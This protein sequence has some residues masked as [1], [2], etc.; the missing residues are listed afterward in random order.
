M[1]LAVVESERAGRNHRLQRVLFV[2]QLWQRKGG[3]G[4]LA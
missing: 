1:M 2:P 4:E 3:F